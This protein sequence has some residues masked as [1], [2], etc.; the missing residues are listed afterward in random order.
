[1]AVKLIKSK[2]SVVAEYSYTLVA[3]SW[4][5]LAF[6]CQGTKICRLIM[7]QADPQAVLKR[8]KREF[9]SAQNDKAILPDFQKSLIDYFLGRKVTFD[10]RVD[11]SWAS[12]FSQAVLQACTRIKPGRTISYGDLAQRAHRPGA[13]RAVGSV[14]AKNPVPLIIPCHR[15]I[16]TNRTLGGYSSP[17]GVG[18][19][20]RLL[21]HE[22]QV[23]S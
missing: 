16:T 8:V 4:G 23:Y 21:E 17:G 2:P 3:T 6:V 20:K 12:V 5:H 9:P 19:K 15:V 13:A 11:V 10:C 1:M 7:P 14:M 22:A 18:L